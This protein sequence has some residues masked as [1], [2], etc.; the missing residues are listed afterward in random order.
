[1]NDDLTDEERSAQVRG[2]L[3]KA[4]GVLVVIGVLIF[5]GTTIMV[6]ALGLDEDSGTG[7]G[8]RRSP[9]A[10][11]AAPDH[12]AAGRRG[13]RTSPSD[14]P[15]ERSRPT[16][17]KQGRIE[18]A[19]SPVLARPME[20]VN[21]TGTYKGADNLQLEVQRFEDGAV[22]RLRG[23]G[24]RPGRHLRDLHHDRPHGREPLPGLRPRDRRGQQRHPG[25]D[26]LTRFHD[27]GK[28]AGAIAERPPSDVPAQPGM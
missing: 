4:L 8:R 6:R 24:H 2:A 20:R 13:T 12:G 22:E 7:P 15:T 25:D 21:F 5:L 16:P 1:M 26:R 17:G 9:T 23:P 27:A 28:L 3:F 14:E 10:D 19:I 18:L 11:Q